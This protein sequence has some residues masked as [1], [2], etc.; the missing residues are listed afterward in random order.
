MTTH[1]GGTEA[2]TGTYLS[3]RAGF[4]SLG[5][6]GGTL[7]GSAEVRWLRVP[8][9]LALAASPILGALF[10]VA[11]PVIG[12]GAVAC[13]LARRLG[14]GARTGAEKLGDVLAPQWTPGEAHLAAPPA[15]TAAKPEPGKAAPPTD[16]AEPEL[17][18]LEGEIRAKRHADR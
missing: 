2:R 17:Q 3:L 6:E 14:A 5:K 16:G 10:I 1:A 4:T 8:T 18:S 11:F 7:P 13:G 12:V 15:P 9:A